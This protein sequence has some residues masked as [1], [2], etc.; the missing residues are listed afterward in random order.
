MFWGGDSFCCTVLLY[1]AKKKGLQSVSD[2]ACHSVEEKK[3]CQ[4]ILL[5]NVKVDIHHIHHYFSL[6]QQFCSEESSFSLSC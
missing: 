6:N 2:N 5:T 3:V 1:A 4:N